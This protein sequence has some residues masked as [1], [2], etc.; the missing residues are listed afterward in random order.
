MMKAIVRDDEMS[1]YSVNV[2]TR[3]GGQVIQ[4]CVS[5]SQKAGTRRKM[6]ADEQVE[7]MG[8]RYG[9]YVKK[10]RLRGD[11]WAHGGEGGQV[12]KSGLRRCGKQVVGESGSKSVCLK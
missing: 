6:S 11:K 5:K 7:V 3:R 1:V 10:T 12:R 2:R 8:I 4:V 9:G